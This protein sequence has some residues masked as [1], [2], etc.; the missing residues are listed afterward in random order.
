MNKNDFPILNEVVY[1]KPLVYLDNA[2]TTQKPHQVIDAISYAYTHFNA[3]IHRGTHYLSQVATQEYEKVRT[4]TASFFNA[5]S[6]NLSC[7][8]DNFTI[9]HSYKTFYQT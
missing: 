7:S 1:N 9:Y 4:L 5:K 6:T 2:A 8:S 3:N